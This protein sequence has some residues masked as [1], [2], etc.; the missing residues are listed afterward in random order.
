MKTVKYRLQGENI[1]FQE[2]PSHG[3]TL[4]PDSIIIHYTAGPSLESAVRTIMD[5]TKK[6]SAHLAV[7]YDGA[8][9]QL[10]PFSVVAWHAGKS[11]YGGRDG[12]NKYSIGIEIVNAGRLEKSGDKYYSWFGKA[13]QEAEVF[14]GVHRNETAPT[15]WHRYTEAQIE[16]V[17]EVCNLLVKE[18]GITLILGH[19]EISPGRKIDPGPAFPLDKLRTRIFNIDRDQDEPI[20]ELYPMAG[21]VIASKLN[22]RSDPS[23]TGAAIA[24]PL[25]Q[26]KKV[27]IMEK[28][29]KWYRVVTEI[30]GWVSGEYVKLDV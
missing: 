16:R 20:E 25:E 12:F 8:I 19:E 15:Y 27:K 2:S 17:E 9:V 21:T 14:Y 28:A 30:E 23:L 22:I 1:S 6:V 4:N 29:G 26:G 24:N 7:D 10:V 5:P 18:Y 11:S 3:A 13:Y